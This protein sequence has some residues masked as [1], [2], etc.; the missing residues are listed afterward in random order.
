M[1][2]WQQE[3]DAIDKELRHRAVRADRQAQNA[4]RETYTYAHRQSESEL[5]RK[6]QLS[7]THRERNTQRETNTERDTDYGEKDTQQQLKE[8]F[9]ADKRETNSSEYAENTQQQQYGATH[10]THSF[11][12]SQSQP[13]PTTHTLSQSPAQQTRQI[14]IVS[15]N[16][17]AKDRERDREREKRSLTPPSRPSAVSL[18]PVH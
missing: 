1:T 14:P 10:H 3:R 4:D 18:Q 5:S 9:L 12:Y 8:P 17:R 6:S 15:H 2:S 11:L 13:T 7:E 16:T